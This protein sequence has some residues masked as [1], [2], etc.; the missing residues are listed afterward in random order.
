MSETYKSAL[1][2][3]FHERVV[4]MGENKPNGWYMI[5]VIVGSKPCLLLIREETGHAS[6]WLSLWADVFMLIFSFSSMSS[7][8]ALVHCLLHTD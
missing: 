8:E 3:T 2:G 4:E 7:L 6:Q 5:M 1:I